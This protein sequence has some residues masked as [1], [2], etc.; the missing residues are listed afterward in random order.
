MSE[1]KQIE[2][3]IRY[4]AGF[5]MRPVAEGE[6]PFPVFSVHGKLET[7]EGVTIA[8]STVIPEMSKS[9]AEHL[10]MQLGNALG[11]VKPQNVDRAIEISRRL[12]DIVLMRGELK[13]TF[14]NRELDGGATAA[15]DHPLWV[16]TERE[17]ED[18]REELVGLI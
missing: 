6:P 2:T 16:S 8:V 5:A 14:A 13:R 7:D 4:V 10:H 12:S 11:I 9:Q 17:I 15:Y 1:P 18:L 3:T